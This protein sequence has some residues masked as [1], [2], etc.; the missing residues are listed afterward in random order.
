M[1]P[2]LRR[3]DAQ[4]RK[5]FRRLDARYCMF[6]TCDGNHFKNA[7]RLLAYIV[8]VCARGIYSIHMTE[9]TRI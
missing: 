3:S 8:R 5:Y 4:L 2:H 9:H 6:Y 7:Y 1:I